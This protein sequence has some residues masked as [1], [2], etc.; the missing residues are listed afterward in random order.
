[1][2]N[3]K[4]RAAKFASDLHNERVT[5]KFMAPKQF[6]RA[7]TYQ[8]Q[9]IC[10]ETCEESVLHLAYIL[11]YPLRLTQS[12]LTRNTTAKDLDHRCSV[13]IPESARLA[14]K[15]VLDKLWQKNQVIQL[16][17]CAHKLPTHEEV[18]VEKR[19]R[20]LD[21]PATDLKSRKP[22]HLQAV[23]FWHPNYM[24]GKSPHQ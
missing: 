8:A 9:L 20:L 2:L 7:T 24:F 19:L 1:M 14:L 15:T 13:C 11:P 16:S 17:T 3:T 6:K 18:C 21:V 22:V 10:S 12:T 5:L 4:G 23:P